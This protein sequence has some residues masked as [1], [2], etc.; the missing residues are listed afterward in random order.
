MRIDLIH[1]I[2]QSKIVCIRVSTP[3]GVQW[4]ELCATNEFATMISKPT[5]ICRH[6]GRKWNNLK[7]MW[8]KYLRDSFAIKFSR[9]AI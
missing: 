9:Y 2:E 8:P 3:F 5:T 7:Y 1:R 4:R 6:P